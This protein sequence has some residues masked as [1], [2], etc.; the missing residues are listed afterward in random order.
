MT[1][2]GGNW[3]VVKLSDW[4]EP[5][6]WADA[7]YLLDANNYDAWV[8]K[9]R[10]AN[11]D[12]NADDADFSAKRLVGVAEAEWSTIPEP[13]ETKYTPSVSSDQCPLDTSTDEETKLPLTG[14]KD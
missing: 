1:I 13:D 5:L 8:G 12:D 11:A 14:S 6:P 3:D 10:G 2:T 7:Y 4:Q 9:L